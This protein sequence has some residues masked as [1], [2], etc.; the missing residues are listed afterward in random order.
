MACSTTDFRPGDLLGFSGADL[1]SDAINLATLGWPR[2]GLSHVGIVT[3]YWDYGICLAESTT[4]AHRPCLAARKR[5]SGAQCHPIKQRVEEY[6]G[7]VW[8]Y[9]LRE[10]L[11]GELV[12]ELDEWFDGLLTAKCPYDYAG[13]VRSRCT[14]YAMIHRWKHGKED[15][16]SLFCSE[17]VA[18]AWKT[19]GVFDTDNASGWNPNA[20]VREAMRQRVVESPIR[21]K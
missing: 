15:L 16:R 2:W 19:I 18:A 13:A 6:K 8:H 5:V 21:L 12:V 14:P 10:P 4:L 11:D 3:D 17:L 1:L 7:R 9:R 20:L